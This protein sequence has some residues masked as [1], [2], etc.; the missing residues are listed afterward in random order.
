[1]PGPDDTASFAALRAFL[2]KNQGFAS[3]EAHLR[4]RWVANPDGTIARPWAPDA[5]VRQS[6]TKEMQAAYKPYAPERIRVPALAVYAA[7]KTAADMMRPWYA[8]DD[9]GL[10]ERVEKLFGLQRAR[11]AHH[12]TWFESFAERRRVAEI[13]GAHHIF[14]NHPREVV[15]LIDGFLASMP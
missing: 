4:A 10:R 12:V 13:P 8:A 15:R 2:E 11:V 1:V 7:P 6:M 9:P 3:P 14:L 5:P